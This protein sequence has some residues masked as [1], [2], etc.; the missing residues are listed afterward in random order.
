MTTG[1]HGFVPFLEWTVANF[2]GG[3][4]RLSLPN[5]WISLLWLGTS[6]VFEFRAW[7][8]KLPF[9]VVT[10]RRASYYIR[11]AGG[12]QRQKGLST[13]MGVLGGWFGRWMK[14]ACHPVIGFLLAL[15]SFYIKG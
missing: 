13:Q 3:D 4:L 1:G 14:T 11:A 15:T 12:G 8:C 2:G 7:P 10:C 6:L 5:E 9:C